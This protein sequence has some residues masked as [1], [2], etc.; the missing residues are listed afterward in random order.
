MIF[1]NMTNMKLP[2]IN[3]Q[4][5]CSCGPARGWHKNYITSYPKIQMRPWRFKSDQIRIKSCFDLLN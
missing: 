5:M 1:D 2:S 3:F 4:V